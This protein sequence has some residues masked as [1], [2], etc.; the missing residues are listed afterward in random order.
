MKNSITED[1]IERVIAQALKIDPT[2]VYDELAYQSIPEWGSLSHVTLMVSL[3][4][5]FGIGESATDVRELVSVSSIKQRLGLIDASPS[6]AGFPDVGT[7]ADRQAQVDRGLA[8][9]ILDTTTITEVGSGERGPVFRG[10]DSLDLFER[11]TLEEVAALLINGHLGVLGDVEQALIASG[12]TATANMAPVL[13]ASAPNE[14]VRFARALSSVDVGFAAP[15]RYDPSETLRREGWALLGAASR[16]IGMS[17]GL[18][19][20]GSSRPLIETI[21]DGMELRV[22]WEMA[23]DALSQIMVLQA[24]NG[25]SAST[26]GLRVA[27]SAGAT[28]QESLSA[29]TLTFGGSLHGGAL[30]SIVEFLEDRTPEQVRSDAEYM[31]ETGRPVPGFGHRIYRWGDPRTPPMERI[32]HRLAEEAGEQDYAEKLCGLR[33]VMRRREALGAAA[34]YDLYAG[35]AWRLIGFEIDQLIP[36]FSVARMIGWIAHAIEQRMSNTLIRP[37]LMYVGD[38]PETAVRKRHS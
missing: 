5:E 20:L 1:Q 19:R 29:A 22:P 30:K 25:A 37:Q 24:D 23:A 10:H 12:M 8:H 26:L 3:A 16:L 15:V 11:H 31:V 33:D 4:N 27:I 13:T 9:T 21:L 36:L 18:P 6:V 17:G 34:N 2:D 35:P 32:F 38:K 14:I 28:L 7:R